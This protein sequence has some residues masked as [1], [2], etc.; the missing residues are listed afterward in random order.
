MEGFLSKASYGIHD[1]K[2][3]YLYRTLS[4]P[5]RSRVYIFFT[6]RPDSFGRRM[7]FS[8]RLGGPRGMGRQAPWDR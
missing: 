6:H 1:C 3:D 8:A 4:V 2:I 7:S 5:F